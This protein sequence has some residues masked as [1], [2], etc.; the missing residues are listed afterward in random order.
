MAI[1]TKIM[2]IKDLRTTLKIKRTIAH[3][4]KCK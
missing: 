2:Y 1:K 3:D 4:K